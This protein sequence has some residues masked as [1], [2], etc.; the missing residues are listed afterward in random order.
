MKAGVAGEWSTAVLRWP[1]TASGMAEPAL[2][3]GQL[4]AR[5]ASPGF[6]GWWSKVSGCGF[7]ARPVHLV[8]A[9]G[10]GREHTVLARCK[11]RRASVCPSC[12][13]LYAADT[14][15]L[16]TAGVRGARH[17]MP[18]TVGSHPAAFVTLTAPS[19]GAVHGVRAGASAA[20]RRCHSPGP[21]GHGDE[22]RT[23]GDSSRWFRQL[24][25]RRCVHSKPLW[26][27]AIHDERD[28]G[29]DV[30]GQPLCG[31]CY[32]YTGHVLFTWWAPEL[33]R[34]FTIAVR[35]ALR[36]ELRRGEHPDGV[37]VSF[38]KVVE[39]QARGI[40]HYHA[41]I[42]LDAAPMQRDEAVAPPQTSISAAELAVLARAAAE[43]VS[44]AVAGGDGSSRVL[45]FGEQMDT[46]LLT[47]GPTPTTAGDSSAE[48]GGVA[49]RVA[50]YLAKYV[51]KSV[52]EFGLSPARISAEAIEALE[53][54]DHVRAIPTTLVGLACTGGQYAPMLSWLHTLG[55][56]GHIT[57]KSRRF[58]VTMAALRARREAWRRQ[59]LDH[60]PGGLVIGEP[61]GW[62]AGPAA[63]ADPLQMVAEWSFVRVGHR[64]AADHYLAVSAAVR[65]REYRRLARDAYRDDLGRD[66][67]RDYLAA[68]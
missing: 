4:V 32:D 22:R 39:L 42:R 35:R 47:V 15:Q 1:V 13:D 31:Q 7:C 45:R 62:S 66:A 14:W 10:A 21:V 34:R 49:R 57:T 38:V 55:Y 44:L 26:C 29:R 64:C 50:G 3:V 18:D 6:D 40:P 68:V 2:A 12:S 65:A 53:L 36:R 59:H 60:T 30:V 17:G 67:H 19:F 23:A 48:Q 20:A 58:S 52:A 37:A 27:T 54:R 41:V 11:N 25:Y 51:T 56:R 46:Q 8:G 61:E 43:R 16:V 63:Y 9:D 5:A 33:W 24:G 28:D